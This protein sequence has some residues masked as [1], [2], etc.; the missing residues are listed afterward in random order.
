[1]D[2]TLTGKDG[3]EYG[4]ERLGLSRSAK[5][6]F[7]RPGVYAF[8]K[9]EVK[10]FDVLISID[11]TLNLAHVGAM[12]IMGVAVESGANCLLWHAGPAG[13]QERQAI[14]DNLRQRYGV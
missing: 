4:F 13:T 9:H 3:T 11:H 10:G 6:Q 2:V 7:A 5:P 12:S 1:M 8:A 14:V